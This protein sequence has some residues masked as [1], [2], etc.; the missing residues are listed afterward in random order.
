MSPLRDSCFLAKEQFWRTAS[1]ARSLLSRTNLSSR[2]GARRL[3]CS[4]LP[5]RCAGVSTR[6]QRTIA[7]DD[8]RS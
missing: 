6:A 8:P 2:P 7:R 3:P 5:P 4:L 1:R